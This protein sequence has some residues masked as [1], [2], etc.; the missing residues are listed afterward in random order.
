MQNLLSIQEM[1][2]GT[3]SCMGQEIKGTP[4]TPG[5]A[6]FVVGGGKSSGH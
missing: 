2:G 3:T 4:K 5:F 1:L 6:Q